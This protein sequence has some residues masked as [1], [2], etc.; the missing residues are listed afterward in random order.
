M[1]Y[2]RYEELVYN[3][4][5]RMNKATVQELLLELEKNPINRKSFSVKMIS[6][7]LICL[8]KKGLIEKSK[9]IWVKRQQKYT[10]EWNIKTK[11]Y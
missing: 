10:R 7:Y 4:L 6:Q 9:R 1:F 3:T 8:E 5:R 11:F 2:N